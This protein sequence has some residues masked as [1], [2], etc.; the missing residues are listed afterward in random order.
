MHEIH[1][2]R[3]FLLPLGFGDFPYGP[4]MTFSLHK[5]PHSPQPK[6]AW[7]RVIPGA[8]PYSKKDLERPWNTAPNSLYWYSGAAEVVKGNVGLGWSDDVQ[9]S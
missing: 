7:R 8:D 6:G 1:F 4:Q 2:I 3:K 5:T 9:G